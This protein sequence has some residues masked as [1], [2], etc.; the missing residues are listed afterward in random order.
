MKTFTIPKIKEKIVKN[1][2]LVKIVLFLI[3][4]SFEAFLLK[5]LIDTGQSKD[6]VFNYIYVHPLIGGPDLEMILFY[7]VIIF[8]TISFTKIINLKYKDTRGNYLFLL[9][10]VIFYSLFFFYTLYLD[11]ITDKSLMERNLIFFNMSWYGSAFIFVMMLLLFL[12]TF[13]DL[14]GLFLIFHKK[15]IISGILA[16]IYLKV[17]DFLEPY[18]NY[19]AMLSVRIALYSLKFF[20]NTL[21]IIP[22]KEA[23]IVHFSGKS[24][25]IWR[26]CSGALGFIFFIFFF[27]LYYSINLKRLNKMRAMFVF[28]LGFFIFFFMDI[29]RNFV[30]VF[31]WIVKTNLGIQ[32]FHSNLRPIYYMLIILLVIFLFKDWLIKD[33]KHH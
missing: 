24:V 27:L 21:R 9:G 33:K 2:V 4:F 18:F 7:F 22:W 1:L 3:I 8:V 11:R 14:K 6:S 31:T 13:R 32:L 16:V 29:F 19:V 26:A 23:V 28:V 15:I 17:S 20:Y 5:L 25:Q 30:F 10:H 12:F